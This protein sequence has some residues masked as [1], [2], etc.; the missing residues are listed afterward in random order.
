MAGFIN[1]FA[2][3]FAFLNIFLPHLLWKSN[4]CLKSSCCLFL[5]RTF[6]FLFFFCAERAARFLHCTE[7]KYFNSSRSHREGKKMWAFRESHD[8]AI[9][10]LSVI[11]E[12][13]VLLKSILLLNLFEFFFILFISSFLSTFSFFFSYSLILLLFNI[14]K[15][16]LSQ[17]HTVYLSIIKSSCEEEKVH[18][19]IWCR[20]SYGIKSFLAFL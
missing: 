8:I 9:L 13:K 14:I 2:S 5:Y 16:T 3:C 20:L 17:L 15:L 1:N 6:F 18:L 7:T 11:Y 12:T 10:W 4:S 19:S